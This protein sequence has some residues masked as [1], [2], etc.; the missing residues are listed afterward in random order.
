MLL[1]NSLIHEERN[2]NDFKVMNIL[3]FHVF[4][5]LL[6]DQFELKLENPVKVPSLEIQCAM[7]MLFLRLLVLD[8]SSLRLFLGCFYVTSIGLLLGFRLFLLKGR[9]IFESKP[10]Q[11]S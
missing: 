5:N 10:F 2:L 7:L 9:L 3:T 1:I 4:E 6:N 8:C 11:D